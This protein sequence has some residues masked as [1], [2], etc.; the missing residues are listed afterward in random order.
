MSDAAGGGWHDEYK[1]PETEEDATKR[2]ASARNESN[3]EFVHLLKEKDTLKTALDEK[4]KEVNQVKGRNYE[5]LQKTEQLEKELATLKA[6]KKSEKE[7]KKVAAADQL[8]AGPPPLT[9]MGASPRTGRKLR[10]VSARHPNPRLKPKKVVVSKPTAQVKKEAAEAKADA[11]KAKLQAEADKAATDKDTYAYYSEIAEKYPMLRLSVLLGAEKKFIE[12]DINGDG[13]ID[14]QELEQILDTGKFMFT[15]QQIK[16]IV[17]EIDKDGSN[18]LDFMECLLIID[19]LQ[20][21]KKTNLPSNLEQN[22]SSVCV[23]Q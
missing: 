15:N 10:P 22:K 23:V 4:E 13:T 20:Q 11:A 17:S 19:R 1:A 8:A 6:E 14:S 5:L 16:D 3:K 21:H 12:A 9:S 2:I 18:D 7:A